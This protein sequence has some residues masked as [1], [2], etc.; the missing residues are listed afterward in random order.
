MSSAQTKGLAVD[1]QGAWLYRVGGISALLV[2]VA[3]VIT[4][5]LYV[6]V[7]AP[8]T[9]GGEARLQYL[10]GKSA[11]WWAI[12]GLSVFTDLLFVPLALAL[13]RALKGVNRDVM[14]VATAC[15]T[16]GKCQEA[17][18]R[19]ANRDRRVVAVGVALSQSPR[20]LRSI[21]AAVATCCSWVVCRPR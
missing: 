17:G 1:P 4:I 5:G 20:R 2:G 10:V 21:A 19:R 13:Y 14:A 6:R 16:V 9:G 8:P 18:A 15:D 7:G 3:Y 12:L 11:E